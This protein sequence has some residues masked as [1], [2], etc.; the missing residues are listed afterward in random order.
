VVGP[1]VPLV[2]VCL[3]VLVVL[4]SATPPFMNFYFKNELSVLVVVVVVKTTILKINFY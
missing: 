2:L 3:S 1:K 4:A